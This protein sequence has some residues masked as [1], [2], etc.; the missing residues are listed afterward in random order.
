MILAYKN[1]TL[2]AVSILKK[3]PKTTIYI[4]ADNKQYCYRESDRNRKPFCGNNA[5]YDAINWIRSLEK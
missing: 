4:D 2:I 1:G 5:V 3:H